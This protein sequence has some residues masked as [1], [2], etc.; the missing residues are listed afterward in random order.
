MLEGDKPNGWKELCNSC[1]AKTC[2]SDH[3]PPFVSNDEFEKIQ[4]STGSDDFVTLREINNELKYIMKTKRNSDECIF[5]DSEKGCTIYQNRP[6][7]CKI[8]PFDIYKFNGEY[9][10]IVYACNPN[11]NWKCT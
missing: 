2:C 6:F 9:T 7:D 5:F 8:F 3:L 10:W 11:S 4:E 1:H